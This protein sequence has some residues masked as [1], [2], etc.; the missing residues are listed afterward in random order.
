MGN[1]RSRSQ[2]PARPA[3]PGSWDIFMGS[4]P[5][6]LP[7]GTEAVI[8]RRPPA[9][10]PPG[11]SRGG[12]PLRWRPGGR[13]RLAQLLIQPVGGDVPHLG[14]GGVVGRGVEIDSEGQ[15][16]HDPLPLLQGIPGRGKGVGGRLDDR[17]P[18]VFQGAVRG[19]LAGHQQYAVFAGGHAGGKN[20]A[21][22]TDSG[23][24][25]AL[26]NGILAHTQYLS[27]I[28]MIRTGRPPSPGELAP[29]VRRQLSAFT[30]S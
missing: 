10:S 29:D 24:V 9:G 14:V 19:D 12:W 16:L 3:H 13:H 1:S 18:V 4:T 11:R 20:Q 22:V 6:H 23:L 7:P 8:R 30:I 27:I 2:V 25:L 28:V 5:F 21:A 26:G 15:D 17:F